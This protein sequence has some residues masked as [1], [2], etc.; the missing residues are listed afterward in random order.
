[1]NQLLQQISYKRTLCLLFMALS[2]APYLFSQKIIEGTVTDDGIS[3]PGVNVIVQGTN[4]GTMTNFDGQ[5]SVEVEDQ[6]AILIFS[7]IGYVSQEVPVGSNSTIDITLQQDATALDEIVVTGY[8]TV[9]KRD[10]IGSISKVDGDDLSSSQMSGGNFVEGLQGK[11]PGLQIVSAGGAPGSAVQVKVRGISS[12]SSGTSPLFVVDGVVG[13]GINSLNPNDIASIEVLKDASATAIYGAR[14]SNGVIIITTKSANSSEPQ[15]SLSVNSG[16]SNWTN[17]DIGLADTDTYFDIMDQAYAN[18]GQVFDPQTQVIDPRWENNDPIS[19]A[20]AEGINSDWP[21]LLTQTGSF[22]DLSFSASQKTEGSNIYSSVWYRN[23]KGVLLNSD[24]SQLAGR[25]NMTFNKG[26]LS[27]G[28][29]FF[30]KSSERNFLNA[31][32]G[33]TS[34]P[35]VRVSD[36]ENASG[37]WNGQT[38]N[39]PLA[40]I[41]S[42]LR[43][44]NGKT[45]QVTGNIFAELNIGAVQGLSVKTEFSPSFSEG[46][47]TN[48]TSKD[49]IPSGNA[50]GNVG[51]ESKIT[52]RTQLFNVYS[53]WDRN[54]DRHDVNIV[55]GHERQSQATHRIFVGGNNLV[56][57]FQEVNTPGT[58]V[59]ARSFLDPLSESNRLS[60][61]SR[62]NYK[63]DGKYLLGA[64]FTREG[65][66]QFAP[67]NRYG[68]FYSFSAGWIVSEEAFFGDNIFSLLKLRGS[69]G[70]TGNGNIPGGI[71][72]SR[73]N[74]NTGSRLYAEQ[75]SLNVSVIGNRDV[76][77]EKLNNLDIG[78]DYGL[79]QDRINGSL[80]YYQQDI[81]SLLLEVTLPASAGI[82]NNNGDFGN[83]SIW[84]NVGDMVN[85]GIEFDINGYVV[86]KSDFRWNVGFNFST[87]RNEVKSISPE[88]DAS[89]DG[90]RE[91]LTFTKR[92]LPIGTYFMA[93]YAGVDPE[94]GIPMIQEVDLEKVESEGVFEFTGNVIP[95]SE[96]NA[97]SHK[98]PILGKNALP[99]WFGGF[100]NT[101]NFKNVDLGVDIYFQGGN[102]IYNRFAMAAAFPRDGSNNVFSDLLEN[103]W[104]Q[105]GDNAKYPQLTAAQRY[106]YD[107]EGNPSTAQ[108]FVGNTGYNTQFLEK[109]DYLRLRNVSLGYTLSPDICEKLLL[110]NARVYVS[111]TNLL[112]ITGFS[113]Y[114]PEMTLL[115]NSNFRGIQFNGRELP[116][117]KIVSMGL[118]IRF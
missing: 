79:F 101:F 17:T 55:L 70:Q 16:I 61:F 39:N 106:E 88:I 6:D 37:Y 100:N 97:R 45:V 89:G 20:E 8:G 85:S 54:F 34:P 116:Q 40:N 60:Y 64:S 49:I 80:A 83:N 103:S 50:L 76:T 52:G 2:A 82:P 46:H 69:Y 66:S 10:V 21:S 56:G 81:L 14:G 86:N 108:I 9:K 26:P 58:N 71:I 107:G 57:N 84:D 104:K 98:I 77:W 43:R 93:E 115:N 19:R 23:D 22:Q 33:S 44:S 78:I 51:A 29:R 95:A 11:A 109:A 73:F 112:T 5:Y 114:D 41:D 74:L 36:S 31:W 48:W 62:V 94:R 72:D 30:G 118:D 102:Y 91:I 25:L 67:E 7:Y 38:G 47:Q 117:S 1:M 3:L 68:S 27:Y 35:W 12:I 59:Q 90:I 32:G 92:G 113:G 28:V 110:S 42:D 99:K 65:Y 53:T 96:N 75:P 4:T 105:P 111:A 63:Y 24:F 18:S 87:N 13:I 15:F